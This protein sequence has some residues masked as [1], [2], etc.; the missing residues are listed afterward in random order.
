MSDFLCFRVERNLLYEV[1][2]RRRIIGMMF[3]IF[4]FTSIWQHK[5]QLVVII[6][7]T[8][9]AAGDLF[10]V[11]MQIPYEMYICSQTTEICVLRV[12]QLNNKCYMCCVAPIVDV[13]FY[14]AC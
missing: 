9:C 1:W 14:N 5:L 11:L 3:C 13:I 4:S 8:V 12:H 2:E 7:N 10:S 6:I